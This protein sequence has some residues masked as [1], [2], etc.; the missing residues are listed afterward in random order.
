MS[1]LVKIRERLL[2]ATKNQK[3]NAKNI[4]RVVLADAQD[5]TSDDPKL[6]FNLFSKLKNANDQNIDI[7]RQ[8][9]DVQRIEC[10]VE[11]NDVLD[12]LMDLLPKPLTESSLTKAINEMSLDL[13]APFGKIIG[14]VMQTL[15]KDGYIFDAK[16]VAPI[17]EKLHKVASERIGT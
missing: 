3:Q 1:Y 15:K 13:T 12:E 9:G 8:R 6:F 16:L 14:Q 2:A 5:F 17:V 7:F 4:L 11:E 10:L